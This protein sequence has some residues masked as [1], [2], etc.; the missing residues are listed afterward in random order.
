MLGFLHLFVPL[1]RFELLRGQAELETYRFNT[2]A[3]QHFFCRR[4]GIQSFY[5]PR[6]HPDHYSINAR[7]LDG[8]DPDQIEREPFDGQNWEAHVE[9]IR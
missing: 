2:G 8:I 7:C 5:R 3:A 1:Q 4:C 6:S 9:S